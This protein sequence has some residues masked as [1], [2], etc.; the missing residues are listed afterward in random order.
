[1]EVRLLGPGQNS[2]RRRQQGSGL[3]QL[4]GVGRA[5]GAGEGVGVGGSAVSLVRTSGAWGLHRAAGRARGP[6]AHRPA[7]GRRQQQQAPTVAR[8]STKTVN[9][10]KPRRAASEPGVRGAWR[11][12]ASAPHAGRVA[13][14]R[15]HARAARGRNRVRLP[16]SRAREGHLRSRTPCTEQTGTVRT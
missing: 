4:L 14:S 10:S 9:S 7:Q 16:W 12:Q 11:T 8:G 1:M 15:R 5:H 13:G 2:G 3:R 6:A